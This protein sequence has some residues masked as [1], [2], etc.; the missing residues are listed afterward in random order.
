[1]KIKTIAGFTVGIFVVERSI[2]ATVSSSYATPENAF[3][4]ILDNEI[5]ID[6]LKQ[7]FINNFEFIPDLTK[8]I[9]VRIPGA[10]AVVIILN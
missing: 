6:E 7:E 9:P 10:N 8:K 1:M 4:N 3:D 2:H 5:L